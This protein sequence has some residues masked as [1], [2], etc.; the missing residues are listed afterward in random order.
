MPFSTLRSFNE[1]LQQI[2]SII[3]L[4]DE[5]RGQIS[6]GTVNTKSPIDDIYWRQ[7]DY[8]SAVLRL[9]AALERYV[10]DSIQKWLDWNESKGTTEISSSSAALERYRYGVGEILKR[11]TEPRFS[12][13]NLTDLIESLSNFQTGI[14]KS[15]GTDALFATSANLRLPDIFK[16]LVDVEV[17]DPGKWFTGFLQLEELNSDNNKTTEGFIKDLVERRNEAAHGNKL[18][19]DFWSANVI[20]ES[21]EYIRVF[22]NCL[23][24]L[25]A[26]TMIKLAEA[27]KI[28]DLIYL[29]EVTES[30]KKSS[31]AIIK[32]ENSAIWIGMTIIVQANNRCYL[33]QITSIKI[34][35]IPAN[36]F[37]LTK[38][39]EAGVQTKNPLNK[40]S[41]I[42]YIDGISWL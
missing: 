28:S 30:F 26:N 5:L 3:K 38:N 41:R 23:S 36:A 8:C 9:Y 6:K 31:A 12:K 27:Q 11:S 22:A 29:G 14:A 42:F 15:I 13:I 35:N 25:I 39:M 24:E 20:I 18:P 1:Q 37:L 32:T 7:Y 19:D 33:D 2:E 16:V 21:I 4:N 17:H 40:K 10:I 34:N